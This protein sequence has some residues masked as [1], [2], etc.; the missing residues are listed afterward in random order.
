MAIQ[1]PRFCAFSRA[2][3]C[4]AALRVFNI[5]YYRVKIRFKPFTVAMPPAGSLVDFASV[6]TS[7]DDDY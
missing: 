1:L 4:H 3:Q 2:L 7:S 6:G 5:L